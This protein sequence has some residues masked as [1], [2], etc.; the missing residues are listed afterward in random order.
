MNIFRHPLRHSGKMWLLVTALLLRSLIA[1]GFMLEFNPDSLLG[2]TV[3]PCSG[4]NSID[5]IKGLTSGEHEHAG[6][7][8]VHSTDGQ[9]EEHTAISTHCATWS[10]GNAFMVS[11]HTGNQGLLADL[12]DVTFLITRDNPSSPYFPTLHHPSRAPPLHV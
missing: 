10:V 4:M 1:P 7:G 2:V 8:S 6:H 12:R 9:N 3:S 11:L 5:A